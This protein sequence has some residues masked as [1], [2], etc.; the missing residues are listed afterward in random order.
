LSFPLPKLK[1]FLAGLL[2]GFLHVDLE[3]PVIIN[4]KLTYDET[5]KLLGILEKDRFVFGYTLEDLNGISPT[6][7]THCIPVDPSVVP[8][9]EPHHRLNNDMREVVKKEF[10]KLLHV[11]IIYPVPHSD[12]ISPV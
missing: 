3:S 12:W 8:T 1:A 9:R 7:C 6:L 2:Y 10:L 4:D 11:G 5:R